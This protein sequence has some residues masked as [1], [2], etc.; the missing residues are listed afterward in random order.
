MMGALLYCVVRYEA[1][2]RTVVHDW[3]FGTNFYI[4]HLIGTV[5]RPQEKSLLR[6]RYMSACVRFQSLL[7]NVRAFVLQSLYRQTTGFHVFMYTRYL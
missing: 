7:A 3:I 2:S 4:S 5:H 6:I 1:I